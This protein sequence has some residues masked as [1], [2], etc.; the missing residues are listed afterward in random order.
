M[1]RGL[2]IL[3]TFTPERPILGVRDIARELGMHEGT[4][5]RYIS[6][7]V[8]LGYL[9]Q[10][11]ERK[12]RL[13]L[14]VTRLGL[15]ALSATSLPEHAHPY[16]QDL[17]ND[18]GYTIALAVLDDTE[19]LCLTQT[20]STR[21]RH[22]PEHPDP[23]PKPRL[24]LHCTATGKLLL[25]HLP[26]KER[27]TLLRQLTLTPHTPKTITR[28]QTLRE[29]I[30]HTALTNLAIN[31]EELTPGQH[32]IAVPVRPADQTTIAALSMSATA[33]TIS[34]KD[35]TKHLAPHLI[36]TADRISARLGYRRPGETE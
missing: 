13:T 4:T 16:M 7:L 28:K 12:Y 3:A 24:P 36:A 33:S 32:A 25:A 19:I 31:N 15:S 6:T 8:A 20:H 30:Q 35:L 23:H 18:C 27:T 29:E 21:H 26:K 1:Q 10:G 17:A 14:G 34:I 11:K 9:E 2:A 5:H 22:T